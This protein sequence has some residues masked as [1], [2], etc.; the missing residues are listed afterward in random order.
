MAS[1]TSTAV[2]AL[3][4]ATAFF[5]LTADG[6]AAERQVDCD[7]VMHELVNG[8]SAQEVARDLGI[9]PSTVYNCENAKAATVRQ[10]MPSAMPSISVPAIVPSPR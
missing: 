10:A 9:S 6:R 7:K 1:K 3:S 2:F 5:L 4:F 8:K